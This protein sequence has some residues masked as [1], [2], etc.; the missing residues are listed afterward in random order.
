MTQFSALRQIFENFL[1]HQD[2][3]INPFAG[4]DCLLSKTSLLRNEALYCGTTF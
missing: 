3:P 4:F 2:L 1:G